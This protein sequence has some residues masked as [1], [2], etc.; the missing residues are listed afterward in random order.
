MSIDESRWLRRYWPASPTTNALVCFPHAGGS[1]SFFRPMASTLR[2]DID[3]LA[4]QYPGRGYRRDE[5]CCTTIEALAD[6]V[7]AELVRHVDRPMALFGHSMGATVAFE[8]ARR[9]ERRE[10]AL[11]GLFVSG[12]PAPSHH[13]AHAVRLHDLD[14][15]LAELHRLGGT[16]PR[17]LADHGT[18]R[19]L[20]PAF[21]ADYQALNA[22]R[23]S[24]ET[25]ALVTAIHA[26][27]GVDDPEVSLDEAAAWRE[28]TTGSFHLR[29][30]PGDHFYL[31]Y[32][33]GD[34]TPAI[35]AA[36]IRNRKP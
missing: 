18:L 3:V 1:A 36:L 29:V 4:V 24:P 21:R 25:A 28:H 14:D 17:L 34:L 31:S 13:R 23:C 15:V 6:V 2:D 5:P 8:V 12:R 26:Y 32:P 11:L 10:R 33:E 27:L 7:T 20:V 22:Y 19:A 9:L 35:R 30:Y 16:D